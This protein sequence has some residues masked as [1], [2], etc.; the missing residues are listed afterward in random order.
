MLAMGALQP[1]PAFVRFFA[2]LFNRFPTEEQYI[3]WFTEAGFSDVR[4]KYIS[5]PW[6]SQQYALAICGTKG[7][8]TPQPPRA[9]QP[10]PSLGSR[11]RGLIY[12]PLALARFGVGMAAF[13]AGTHRIE[14]HA[15]AQREAGGGGGRQ[16]SLAIVL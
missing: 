9:A 5:N 7:D 3:S 8:A 15:A 13:A 14:R 16:V 10:A 11:L 4:T 6:N 12:L 2:T 1:K